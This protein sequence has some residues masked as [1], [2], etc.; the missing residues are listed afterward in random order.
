M[1]PV[2]VVPLY[3]M[4]GCSMVMLF[5][6]AAYRARGGAYDAPLA[7]FAPQPFRGAICR[8]RAS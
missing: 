5:F 6:T 2:D 4:S 1:I 7:R 8:I 3:M